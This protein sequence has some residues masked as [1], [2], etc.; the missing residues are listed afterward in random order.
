MTSTLKTFDNP[1]ATAPKVLA[2]RRMR[3]VLKLLIALPILAAPF[4]FPKLSP[5]LVPGGVLA[6]IILAMVGPKSERKWKWMTAEQCKK[7]NDE[8]GTKWYE[9][10]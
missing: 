10:L 4:V 1:I 7:F 8:C 6:L 3:R 2:A 5:I 9:R